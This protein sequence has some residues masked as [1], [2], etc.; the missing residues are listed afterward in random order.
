VAEGWTGRKSSWPITMKNQLR[1]GVETDGRRKE[2]PE[3]EVVSFPLV[4]SDTDRSPNQES[5]QGTVMVGPRLARSGL[6]EIKSCTLNRSYNPRPTVSGP[7]SNHMPR[8]L[9]HRK[10]DTLSLEQ[11]SWKRLR[12]P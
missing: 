9:G 11:L 2:R 8:G 4:S 10:L 12:K 3:K 5:G 1:L 7:E 6:K